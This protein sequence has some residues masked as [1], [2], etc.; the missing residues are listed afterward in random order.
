MADTRKRAYG[1]GGKAGGLV[2]AN[3]PSAFKERGGGGG[4]AV[5][6]KARGTQNNNEPYMFPSQAPDDKDLTLNLNTVSPAA[7]WGQCNPII[8]LLVMIPIL[9]VLIGST[10]KL[11]VPGGLLVSGTFGAVIFVIMMAVACLK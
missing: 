3:L 7:W 1:S 10:W 6:G 5:L 9:L 2:G 4:P 11:G 8:Y